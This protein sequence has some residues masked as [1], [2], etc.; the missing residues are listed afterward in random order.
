LPSW[1]EIL[2]E[3]EETAAERGGN[4]DFDGV[5]RKYLA[6]LHA[7]TGRDT[8]LYS[9]DWLNVT[10]P[11]VSIRLADMQGL[12]EVSRDLSGPELDIILHSPGGSAEATAS[13]VRYLRRKFT[14]MRVFVPLAAMSA[15]TMWALAGDEIVLG[16]HSQLGPIDPQ[17]VTPQGQSPARGIIQQFER[18]KRE[19]TADPS[20]VAAWFPI[21]QQYAPALLEQCDKAE[22][23]AERLVK[24]WLATFMFGGEN[25]AAERASKVAA[26]FANYEL[27]QSHSLGITREDARNEGVIIQDL[28]EDQELQDLVLSVHHATLH[29][30][31]G[32][33]AKIVENHLGRAFVE[34]QQVVQV[35]I[36][37]GPQPP[38]SQPPT[39][40][41]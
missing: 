5:R 34:M 30:F 26:F 14:D 25:D 38:G 6:R 1:G 37:P 7:H 19:C 23:L 16:K 9:S 31:Q 33:A 12:M 36:P 29:T 35:Q 18:A 17:L 28:E 8:I 32:A 10:H 3:L 39:P 4:P 15:A 40:A 27:H 13:I 22:R 11:V 2:N 20:A 24:E 21:L 41:G